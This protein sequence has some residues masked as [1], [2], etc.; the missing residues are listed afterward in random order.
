DR[1]KEDRASEIPGDDRADLFARIFAGERRHSDGDRFEIGARVDIDVARGVRGRAGE[2]DEAEREGREGGA[3]EDETNEIHWAI[4]RSD[5]DGSPLRR[6]RAATCGL[7][8]IDL[9]FHCS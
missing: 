2:R 9:V 1:Q 5:K 3:A 6:H 8:W 7:K 4:S